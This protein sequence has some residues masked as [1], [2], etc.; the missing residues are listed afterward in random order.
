VLGFDKVSFVQGSTTDTFTANLIDAFYKVPIFAKR[1]DSDSIEG[2]K[3]G[4]SGGG[5]SSG[6]G[7]GGQGG[8]GSNSPSIPNPPGQGTNQFVQLVNETGS[9]FDRTFNQSLWATY[10]NPFMDYNKEM[11]GV[12]ELLL[13]SASFFLMGTTPQKVEKEQRQQCWGLTSVVTRKSAIEVWAARRV[14]SAR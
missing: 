1:G 12:T 5:N 4:G 13:V 14:L 6:G 3:D 11:S 7:A 10:P 9:S 2:R 8:S